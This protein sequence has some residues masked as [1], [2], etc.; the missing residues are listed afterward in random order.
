MPNTETQTKMMSSR[1]RVKLALQHQAS[2][3][4]P[5]D[6]LATPEIWRGLVEYL[7]LD[8]EAVGPSDFFDP[9]WEALCAI[10]RSIVGCYPM[11]NFAIHRNRSSIKTHRL[12]GGAHSAA[13]R[14]TAC[15][16]SAC[17]MGR[18]MTFG[19]GPSTLLS[20]PLGPTRKQPAGP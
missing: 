2:D 18:S 4:V 15:G 5:V 3:R 6:F 1:E 17:P 14:P 10:S 13:R 20:T 19:A 16:V 9:T 7:N 8:S 11:I 12:I